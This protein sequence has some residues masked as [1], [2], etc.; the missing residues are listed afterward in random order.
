MESRACELYQKLLTKKDGVVATDA[1]SM[2]AAR[3]ALECQLEMLIE[4]DLAL[5]W[6]EG[7]IP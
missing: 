1:D 2:E 7:E 4:D 5:G 6:E 3:L